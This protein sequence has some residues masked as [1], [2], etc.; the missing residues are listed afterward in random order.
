MDPTREQL[1]LI[2]G[3][4]PGA[5]AEDIRA[6]YRRAAKRAHPDV[7][8][9]NEAF[10]LVQMAADVLL[11]ELQ[12]GA[13]PTTAPFDVD[14]DRTSRK[15]LWS[16]VT[17]E[18]KTKWRLMGEPVTVFAPYKIGLSQFNDGTR[19]NE[20]AYEWLIR[21]IGARGEHWDF[22]ITGSVTRIFFRAEDDARLFQMRFH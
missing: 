7:G 6:A 1:R 3:V 8:G 2:L 21:T 11:A 12:A 22:H 9:S 5:V 15:G 20:H 18:L 16:Y 10:R 19:L 13:S 17:F 4:G 14:A